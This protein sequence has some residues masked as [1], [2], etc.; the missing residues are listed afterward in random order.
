MAPVQLRRFQTALAAMT[1]LV[2]LSGEA[3]AQSAPNAPVISRVGGRDV[4]VGETLYTNNNQQG[5]TTVS[6]AFNGFAQNGTTVYLYN[7]A[8]LIASNI[9]VTDGAWQAS[10][11]MTQ[12]HYTFSAKAK[13]A[14]GVYSPPS[15]P[16]VDTIVDTRVPNVTVRLTQVWSGDR[17]YFNHELTTIYADV[18]DPSS[19]GVSSGLDFSTATGSILD[20]TDNAQVPISVA[21]DY[22][23]KV[24]LVPT[25]G[26][27][28]VVNATTG[29]F[30]NEHHYKSTVTIADR[31]GNVGTYTKNMYAD[32][33]YGIT[34]A[35]M[36]VYDPNHAQAL[37]AGELGVSEPTNNYPTTSA[38]PLISPSGVNYGAGWVKYYKNMHI[39]TNPTHMIVKLTPKDISPNQGGFDVTYLG[40]Y[41]DDWATQ[42]VTYLH[43][44]NNP[45]ATLDAD[46][47]FEG[48]PD[49]NLIKPKGYVRNWFYP[50]DSG[51]NRAGHNFYYYTK[52]GKPQSPVV[53]DLGYP[54]G[55]PDITKPIFSDAHNRIVPNTAGTIENSQYKS[56]VY[57]YM[58]GFDLKW[59]VVVLSQGQAYQNRAGLYDDGDTWYDSDGDWVRDSNEPFADVTK[60]AVSDGR[61]WQLVN[62][63]NSRFT[64]SK[65]YTSYH[66]V[67]EPDTGFQSDP[68]QTPH[69]IY[70]VDITYPTVDDVTMSQGLYEPDT[71]YFFIRTDQ[72]ATIQANIDDYPFYN[73]FT[74]IFTYKFNECKL[75][76]LNQ[77]SQVIN[78]THTGTFSKPNDSISQGVGVLDLSTAFTSMTPGAYTM[79]LTIVDN[80]GNTTVDSSR[81]LV[82]DGKAPDVTGIE[83]APGSHISALTNFQV[84]LYD[85]PTGSEPVSGVSFGSGDQASTDPS[86]SQLRPLR[87]LGTAAASG[88]TLVVS[89]PLFSHTG[90]DLAVVGQ[91]L[92]AWRTDQSNTADIMTV[93]A[94]NGDQ[95]TLTSQNGNLQSGSTYMLLYPIDYYHSSNA[96]DT[97]SANPIDPITQEGY[98]VVQVRAVDRIGN[99][100]ITLSHYQYGA[101]D[102]TYYSPAYGTFTLTPSPAT[103]LA[104]EIITV[105]SGIIR[106]QNLEQVY[107][108]T[109]VTV[110]SGSIATPFGTILEGDQDEF[111]DGVQVATVN[112]RVTFRIT[113]TVPGTSA[114]SASSGGASSDPNPAI[115]FIPNYPDGDLALQASAASCIANGTTTIEITSA[116]VADQY[117][118]PITDSNTPFNLFTVSVPGFTVDETDLDTG[119]PGVQVKPGADSILR[120]TLRAGTSA[121]NTT[122]TI[123]SVS[124]PA[125]TDSLALSLLP[126]VPGQAITL[127]TGNNTLIAQTSGTTVITSSAIRDINGNT[128]ANGT[129]VTVSTTR[130]TV[131]SQDED[132]G[133][134]G[135]QRK[136]QNGVITIQVSAQ[137][138]Q[139]GDGTV[140]AVSVQG[141]A[142]GSEVLHFVAD[143]P[144]GTMTLTPVPAELIADGVS[145]STVTSSIIRDQYTNPVGAGATVNVSSSAGLLRANSGASWT[146]GAITVST[147]GQGTISFDVQAGS[148]V[149]TASISVQSNSGTAQGTVAIPF[150]AGVPSGIISLSVNKSE[151][152]AGSSD[153]AVVT[154]FVSDQ[155]GHSVADGTAITIAISDGTLIAVDAD[156]LENGMQV[157]TANGTITFSFSPDSAEPGTAV[158]SAD[159]VIGS[160][161]GDAQFAFIAGAPEQPFTLTPQPASI[162]ADGQSIATVASTVIRDIY[163]N[164]VTAGELITVSASS[165]T[166]NASDEDAVAPGIQVSTAA[167]GK[168]SFS[169][170][171][172][173]I[174]GTVTLSA[175]SVNG[176][177]TGSGQI[178]FNAGVP[179]GTITLTADPDSMMANSGQVSQVSSSIIRDQFG[180]TVA[181]GTLI[182]VTA[183]RGEITTSDADAAP[184]IQVSAANGKIQFDVRSSLTSGDPVEPGIAVVTAV[185]DGTAPDRAEGAVSITLTRDVP[186]G[187]ISMSAQNTPLVADGMSE[188]IVTSLPITDRYNNPVGEGIMVSISTTRGSIVEDAAPEAVNNQVLTD[189]ASTITFT[190]RAG[191]SSG[192]ATV[193]ALS[194]VGTAQGQISI[195]INPDVPA[196][197][198]T[199]YALSPALE[200]DGVSST[201]VTSGLITDANG[202]IAADG[203]LVTVDITN[204]TISAADQDGGISGIQVA[205]S[206]GMISFSV[207]SNGAVL[208]EGIISAD[209]VEGSASGLLSIDFIPGSP[210]GIIS[211]NASPSSIVADP[212]SFAPVEG[213]T[214]ETTISSGII[215]DAAANVVADGELFTV[216]TSRGIITS[217]DADPGISGIQV[218]SV[219]GSVSF[220]LSSS[221]STVGSSTVYIS[222]VA[223]SASG[224][225]AVLFTDSG[226]I[227]GIQIILDEDRPEADRYVPWNISRAVIVECF[228]I[229]GNKAVGDTVALTMV[230]NESG[231]SLS[232]YPG[233]PGTGT[234]S[235]W[236]GVTDANGRFLVKYT[237]PAD[238]GTGINREDVLDAHSADVTMDDVDNRRFIVTSN[239]PPLFRIVSIPQTGM[240]GEY[241][242]ITLEIIDLYDSHITDVNGIFPSLTVDLSI[243][244]AAHQTS[245][246]FYLFDGS[247]YTPAGVANVVLQWDANGYADIYYK[248]TQKGAMSLLIEDSADVIE[249]AGKSITIIPNIT[250]FGGTVTLSASP[251]QI[252]ASG[253]SISAITGGP[254]TDPYGNILEGVVFTVSTNRGSIL[255]LDV[256]GISANGVQTA[257]NAA[258]IISFDLRSETSPGPAVVSAQMSPV[259]PN[260]TVIVSFAA[261]SPAGIITLTPD[262]TEIQADGTSSVHV[263]SSVIRDS[264]GNSVT[265]G[266][267]VTISATRGDI[268]TADADGN[269]GNGIQVATDASGA[270]H[271]DVR[272]TAIAGLASIT[273]QSVN[274]SA[275][276]SVSVLFIPGDPASAITLHANPAQV[277]AHAP[278]SSLVTSDPITDGSNIVLDGELFTITASAGSLVALDEDSTRE[279]LQVGSTGGV[280]SFVFNPNTD[281]ST[282]T[283][284]AVS[285]NG[286]ASGSA[287]IELIVGNPYGTINL[288]ADP[289]VITAD[290]VLSSTITSTAMHDRYGN[291]LEA[292]TLFHVSSSLGTINDSGLSELNVACVEGGILSFTVKSGTAAGTATVS[293]ESIEGS[294]TGNTLIQFIPGAPAGAISLQAIPQ[295]LIAK[296]GSQSLIKV[297]NSSPM[298]DSNGN[299][300]A[301]G[302][303]VT[304]STDMGKLLDNGTEVDQM[305]VSAS[306]GIFSLN[307]KAV[308]GPGTAHINAV[309]GAASGSIT[310]SLVPGSPA[311]SITLTPSPAS[312]T[313][314]GSSTSTITS[315]EIKDQYGTRVAAGTPVTVSATAGTI[316]NTDSDAGIPGIQVPALADGTISVTLKSAVTA[317]SSTISVAALSG[318]VLGSCTVAFTAGAPAGSITL[319]P[320]PNSL[321]ARSGDESTVG[322][323][324]IRDANNNPVGENIAVTVSTTRGLIS[325]ADQDALTPGIQVRTNSDSR[326]SF[327]VEADAASG[328]GA[329]QLSAV[330][331]TGSA[332]SAQGAVIQFTIGQPAGTFS[333]TA[334]PSEIVADG[335]SQST[336]TSAPITDQY[337]NVVPAGTLVT[338]TTNWGDIIEDDADPV[339]YP[340]T[341]IAADASGVVSF[342]IQSETVTGTA[343]VSAAST[344]GTAAGSTTVSGIAG[345][346]TQLVVVIPGETFNTAVPE[347][348]TGTPLDQVINVPFAV[349]VYPVDANM[350]HAVRS[351]MTVTIDS[352]SSYMTA[353][354]SFSQT[355][356]GSSGELVF[357]IQDTIAGLNLQLNAHNSG[358]SVSGLSSD[359]DIKAGAPVK[360][361]VLLPGE[362]SVPGDAG[363]GKS[364]SPVPQEAGVPFTVIVQYVDQYYNVVTDVQETVQLTSSNSAGN[365]VLPPNTVLTLGSAVLSITE[366]QLTTPQSLRR[367][368]ASL[369]GHQS[370]PIFAQTSQFIVQDTLAPALRSFT[371]SNGS[372]YT[373][374]ATVSLQADAY[375]AGGAVF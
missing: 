310:V 342:R 305:T 125:T 187:T 81:T 255:A 179:A 257:T 209:S 32:Y 225:A 245:G 19:G 118:N 341:Q 40:E 269:S 188:S 286:S 197:I 76:L 224:N 362:V 102:P 77:S 265:A 294:S 281:P 349:K 345:A 298:R 172:S 124:K 203:T 164:I 258:G 50:Q 44:S 47:W 239:V 275:Q 30:I 147:V 150:I 134:A 303:L 243:A 318:S 168:I 42:R 91:K 233:Y 235:S 148:V 268:T 323:S 350:N 229:L 119:T 62:P 10:V 295:V 312:M 38:S 160:A 214:T 292:G 146:A 69:R 6:L 254:V 319:T 166:I 138:A 202:N 126:G 192:A 373:S 351:T 152:I 320:V 143:N 117:G 4:V 184:G 18:S 131:T 196:G 204:G 68:M 230:Q 21:P 54:D 181:D 374:S 251:A 369:L 98:Y 55:D 37:T 61:T 14:S 356:D 71:D 332:A 99:T 365:A 326:I 244:P 238:P 207:T 358:S 182:T 328:T 183:D 60:S 314:N 220:T 80:F 335:T 167:D 195:Q 226:I 84:T 86:Y 194:N 228:D 213:V 112:G 366:Y 140:S 306:G 73:Y 236:S 5:V 100:N 26:F 165:G 121:Q 372:A 116:A 105:T 135:I 110:V 137:S 234:S 1:I 70:K 250:A 367:L 223:G 189:A 219:S 227:G 237:T 308:N 169:M 324:V 346:V 262:R 20:Y 336:V 198:I 293:V 352:L 87:E 277:V 266:Q 141:S 115:A 65:H 108:G 145:V 357:S 231:S 337:G 212:Y 154:G 274:G 162:L 302:T 29:S 331:V 301:D 360:V 246:A 171:S 340:D 177:A 63:N 330:S 78:P 300:V 284:S 375:D 109:L 178:L 7:G 232:G 43:P 282:V 270:I 290:G 190:V 180:N 22:V 114:V 363:D 56:I 173:T 174:S 261:G 185:G 253:S 107:D 252:V 41:V 97:L 280:I 170:T 155:Y 66:V 193:T 218:A 186:Y 35:G 72:L 247:T 304:V 89:K 283:V 48:N 291:V 85:L 334:S 338:V 176:N 79:K 370:N 267:L 120:V 11:S 279:G 27:G 322:S 45:V 24:D 205:V 13:N 216:Y 90:A 151:M 93:T 272:S 344:E 23:S 287:Q 28:K 311:G 159:S 33:V 59:K 211:L 248:D 361:H 215:T 313:A 256:D 317:G 74:T 221:G 321:I 36:Y 82:V 163:N 158:I 161:Y 191:T 67:R 289:S 39:Y 296:S 149:E 128:V 325:T 307:F 241:N 210:S 200:L 329:A 51:Q 64:V 206:G 123:S 359:F 106:M 288:S 309:S 368:T 94:V 142:S 130:G 136:T 347:G 52:T 88:Q 132:A 46:G 276:G 354:P 122:L 101:S 2:M 57:R 95:V 259:S 222:S 339:N 103:A 144:Y 249:P 133:I 113:R 31:A 297:N 355:F 16:P 263:D 25:K 285:V 264:W 127:S 348:K 273:A 104:G 53:T 278:N 3:Y 333:L 343:S 260:N 217:A 8:N 157:L 92:E 17:T 96:V 327:V 49:P 364:G 139:V 316:T 12:G 201:Q 58:D 153:S 240:A 75:E 83:P 371:I 111:A 9:P 271:F 299:I 199:L 315:S 208:G 156:P 242:L 129:L 353:A 175:Q 15:D 34:V